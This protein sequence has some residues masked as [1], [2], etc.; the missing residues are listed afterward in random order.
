[1][2]PWELGASGIGG[3]GNWGHR[4]LGAL[5]SGRHKS[6]GMLGVKVWPPSASRAGARHA[7]S[8]SISVTWSLW[9]RGLAAIL[10]P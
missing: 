9:Q 5:F 8:L 6:L 2:W 7:E 3:I 1:M 10:G 4:E